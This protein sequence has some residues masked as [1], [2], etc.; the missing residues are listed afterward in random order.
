MSCLLVSTGVPASLSEG[1]TQAPTLPCLFAV[2]S[3][4]V[5]TPPACCG[6]SSFPEARRLAPD[7][8]RHGAVCA[9]LSLTAVV[10]RLARSG[11]LSKET[12]LPNLRRCPQ[13]P[14]AVGVW[15]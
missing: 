6:G 10:A 1:H 14:S 7:G 5:G 15:V 2:A 12:F 3:D 9:C 4:G 13:L 8:P 11:W